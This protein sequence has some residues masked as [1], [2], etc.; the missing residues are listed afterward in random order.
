MNR[1]YAYQC[2]YI[3]KM[4]E[5]GREIVKHEAAILIKHNHHRQIYS[6]DT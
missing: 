1:K 2:Q 6:A 3:G 4:L 5:R